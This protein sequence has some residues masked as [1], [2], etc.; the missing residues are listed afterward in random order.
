MRSPRCPHGPKCGSSCWPHTLNAV[1]QE[2]ILITHEK[3]R[4]LIAPLELRGEDHSRCFHAKERVLFPGSR[5]RLPRGPRVGLMKVFATSRGLSHQPLELSSVWEGA[6]RSSFLHT[7]P[8]TLLRG[9][10]RSV[11][12]LGARGC[13]PGE[14]DS[15]ASYSWPRASLKVAELL[16]PTRRPLREES[17]FI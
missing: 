1:F 5:R 14:Q 4:R 17:N 9:S 11:S 15:S 2:R 16:P 12:R 3:V 7:S 10:G 6:S 13:P 8:G